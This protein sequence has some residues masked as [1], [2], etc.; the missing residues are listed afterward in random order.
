MWDASKCDFCGDCFAQC[1]YVD[2][3]REKAVDEIKRLA[4]GKEAEILKQCITCVACNDYCPTGADP[5]NL[6]FK[7]Q[8][9]TGIAPVD[10]NPVVRD[11][12]AAGLEGR[13]D[14]SQIIPGEPDKPVLS[15]DSF[16]FTNFPEGTLESRLFQ[17]MS[18]VRGPEYMSLVGLVHLGA[19]SF[20]EK[21]AARVIG[22]LAELGKDIVYI[23]N[24][25][26]VLAHVKAREL[27]IAVPFR[28]MHLFEYLIDYL[29]K[30]QK[31]IAKLGKK[32]SVQVNCATRWIPQQD[33]WL[34][35]I[36][37]FVGVERP[38]RQY[39]RVNALCCSLP[40]LNTN[41]TLAVEM[42]E[43]NVRDALDCG[44]QAM[45]T[46][47]PLCDAIMRRPT[48]RL[49]LP[50]LFITDLCRIALGELSWPH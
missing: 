31:D 3:D 15:F 12:L 42:Q 2:F 22:K 38:P 23:H 17:G 6:V 26:Y 5:S 10:R 39:D 13:G 11:E 33:A 9:K 18:V 36:F 45:I 43:K 41:R 29:R 46:I 8:E 1:R 48:S 35:Q 37:E 25:G 47:C 50:K 28:Y 49:G 34:D 40:I 7:M 16:D 14:P 44:A 24:E 32:V 30:N 27:G 21:Y 20:V 19:E 4:A